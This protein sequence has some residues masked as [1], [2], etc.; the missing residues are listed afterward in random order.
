MP[1]RS[2]DVEV[3]ARPLGL[4]Q[5]AAILL[6]TGYQGI[7]RPL[8]VGSCKF[9]PSCSTYAIEAIRDHGLLRGG[10]LTLGRVTRCHPFARGGIDPVP[11][12]RQ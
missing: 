12:A 10:W 7:I 6:V 8:L 1:R 11:P 4:G 9:Y 5:R 2:V 3:A